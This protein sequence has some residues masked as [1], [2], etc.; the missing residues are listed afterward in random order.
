MT[1]RRRLPQRRAAVAVEIEHGG[2]RFRMQIG[3]FAD[4]TPAEL[5]LDAVKQSSALDALAA[6][7]AIL[8]SLFLQY[9]VAPA[10][11]GHALRRSP[12]GEPATLI[13]AVVDRLAEFERE[14]APS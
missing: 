1:A 11:I 5:F 3:C 8:L 7:S 13:G 4:G 12:N 10:E 14:A 2:H 6:D 9:G